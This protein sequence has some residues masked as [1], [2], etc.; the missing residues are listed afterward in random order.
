LARKKL[1]RKELVQK[2]D[3]TSGLEW[4][5]T[6]VV[7]HAVPIGIGV[8]L[9]VVGIAIAVVLN[10]TAANREAA[11]QSALAEVIRIYST[12]TEDTTDEERFQAALVEA[13][14]VE[15]DHPDQPAA[16][17]AR[18]YAGLSHEGLGDS[19]QA[20]AI[21]TELGEAGDETVKQVALFALAES[22]KKEGDL[23]SAIEV[24]QALADSGGYSPSAVLYEL[25]RLYEATSKP[26]EAR[27][28]YQSLVGEYPDSPFRADAD[29]ALRRLTSTDASE[30]PS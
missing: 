20:I 30:E 16:Q 8:G 15:A 21:L 29:S 9:V 1:T 19:D 27:G 14:R 6:Y 24:Y 2:D 18:Y 17:I 11:A 5:T 3:I 23:E 12:I 28:Y 10:V 25:G 4:A 22:H 7:E 13:A 26:E